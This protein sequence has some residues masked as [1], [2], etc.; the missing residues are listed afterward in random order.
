MRRL[1][2][3]G[4]LVG[5]LAGALAAYAQPSA[6]VA[7]SAL[8]GGAL[9]AD[10]AAS[11]VDSLAAAQA[12]LGAREAAHFDSMLAARADAVAASVAWA[13]AQRPWWRRWGGTLAL[14]LGLAALA[15]AGVAGFR[16]LNAR[17]GVADPGAVQRVAE[18]TRAMSRVEESLGRLQAEVSGSVARVE[19]LHAAAEAQLGRTDDLLDRVERAGLF[20][21]SLRQQHTAGD[22]SAA[23][24]STS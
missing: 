6:V 12:A 7:D 13:D 5:A 3:A 23:P 20:R 14:G 10:S 19:A 16:H 8:V 1:A 21:E 2:Y 15:G 18:A 22:L 17:A 24:P 4:L 11:V 9:L